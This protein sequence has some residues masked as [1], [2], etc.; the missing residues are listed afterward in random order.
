VIDFDTFTLML[1]TRPADA[2]ALGEAEQTALQDGHLAHLASL[3]ERGVLVAAGPVV[4]DPHEP[5]RGIGVF[6]VGTDEASALMAQD[7]SVRAGWLD[8]RFETWVCPAGAMSFSPTRFPR[9]VAE[10]GED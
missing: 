3:H 4:V 1:L 9:S 10:V 8:V 7:P 5:L 2:P 6:T